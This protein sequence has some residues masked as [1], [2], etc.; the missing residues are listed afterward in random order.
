MRNVRSRMERLERRLTAPS[1]WCTCP[2]QGAVVALH[3]VG[4]DGQSLAAVEPVPERCPRCGRPVEV[5]DLVIHYTD[6][7]PLRGNEGAEDA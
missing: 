2:G 1:L 4:P 3:E 5:I 6:D 7:P